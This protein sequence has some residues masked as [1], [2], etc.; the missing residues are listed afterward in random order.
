MADALVCPH[1]HGP[2]SRAASSVDCATCAT[3]YPVD[4]FG[5]IDFAPNAHYDRFTGTETLTDEHLRGLEIEIE[6]SRSRIIDYY[7]PML[8]RGS[9]VL[10]CGCGNGIS[11]E[12]LAADGFDTWG[13]DLSELRAWQWRERGVRDRLMIADALHLPFPDGFFDAVISSGVIEH[14]GVE[15]VA[16]PRYAVRP[17]ADRDERRIAFLRE[18]ARVLAP[19]G[20]IFIDCPNGA[21]PI[22]FWHGGIRVHSVREGFLPSFADVRRLANIALP[23]ARVEALSPYRRLQFRQ[24]GRH[25]IGRIAAPAVDVFFRLMTW[26]PFRFLAGTPLNPFLVVRITRS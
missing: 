25:L 12:T 9:R 11:V 14:I 3:S 17:L 4:A 13:I 21:F 16:I 18:I 7:T 24:A 6:G 15:E 5:I 20:T 10:D 2:L 23:D 22:D 26:R 19:G 1:C 8:R